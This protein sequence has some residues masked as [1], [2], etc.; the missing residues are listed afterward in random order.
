MIRNNHNDILDYGISFYNVCIE[1]L[2]VYTI[3]TLKNNAIATR[4]ANLE[5]FEAFLLSFETK[6]IEVKEHDHRANMEM[7]KKG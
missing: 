3:E 1:E 2:N 7:L 4:G 5:D 6:E